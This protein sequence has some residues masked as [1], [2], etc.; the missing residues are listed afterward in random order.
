MIMSNILHEVSSDLS[1]REYNNIIYK[2]TIN[3]VKCGSSKYNFSE[4]LERIL[5]SN[6]RFRIWIKTALNVFLN[7]NL[8]VFVSYRFCL[9]RS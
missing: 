3:I 4:E 9:S 7:Y 8:F 2:L 5:Q 6:F 1:G